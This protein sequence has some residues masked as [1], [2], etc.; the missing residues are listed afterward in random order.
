M[1]CRLVWDLGRFS[2]L[3]VVGI[4]SP[5]VSLFSWTLSMLLGVD[6]WLDATTICSYKISQ[7][8]FMCF[9]CCWIKTVVVSCV[10]FFALIHVYVVSLWSSC[11]FFFQNFLLLRFHLNCYM[12]GFAHPQGST[13]PTCLHGFAFLVIFFFALLKVLLGNI[14][15][16]FS[17]QIQVWEA[18]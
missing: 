18:A 2:L 3:D 4:F 8:I 13:G 5:A 9:I 15:L 11:F 7:V 12:Q 6:A 1:K 17:S 14:F 10:F 16:N